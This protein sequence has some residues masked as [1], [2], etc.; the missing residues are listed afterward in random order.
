MKGKWRVRVRYDVKV[1]DGAAQLA[2]PASVGVSRGLPWPGSRRG[3]HALVKPTRAYR[4]DQL[5]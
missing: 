2:S 5:T 4:D 1:Y 3:W